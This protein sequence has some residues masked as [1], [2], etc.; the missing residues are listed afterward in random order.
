MSACFERPAYGLFKRN[1][2]THRCKVGVSGLCPVKIW[3]QL[4]LSADERTYLGEEEMR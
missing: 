3:L 4:T 2:L 1:L